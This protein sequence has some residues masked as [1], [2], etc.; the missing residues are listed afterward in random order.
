MEYFLTV[1]DKPAAE[2]SID[3]ALIR[4][5]LADQ[6]V[7]M[8][9]AATELPLRKVAEGWDSEV[10]RLGD[11]YAVRLPRR[12][13]AAP[14]VLHEQAVLPGVAERLAPVG[15]RV[16]A[17]VVDGVAGDGYPWAWSVVPWI[18]GVPALAQ[19]VAERG[20]W[21]A[22]LARALSALHSDAP[23]DHPINPFRGVPLAARTGAV[24]ER[25]RTLRAGGVLDGSSADA[26]HALWQAGRAAAPWDRTPVWIHG[27]LHPGNLVSRDGDLAGI[28][29]FGDVTAGDPAYDL[30]VAWLAFDAAGR[31]RFMA[32]VGSR[33][34]AHIWVRAHAWAAA[35][36]LTLLAH[37]D[38]NPAYLALGR[39]A[40]TEVLAKV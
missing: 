11:Q 30:A 15:V 40:A 27:D 19:P 13:L 37:S 38:D 8:I 18:D 35:V 2:I 4:G 5:L 24:E 14:L 23:G 16:P 26:L 3:I 33:Y 29:D 9:P 21:A 22:T 1:P 32:A 39:D 31:E 34:D 10:W 17:P 20:G 28:I 25:L 12:A 6:A 36:V 7:A